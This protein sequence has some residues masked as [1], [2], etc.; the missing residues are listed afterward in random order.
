[1]T[2]GA[3]TAPERTSS[4]IASPAR[5]LSPY[6]S[7][8]IRAGSPWN[9]TRPGASSSQRWSSVSSGKERPERGVY[10]LDVGR[11]SG[12][13]RPPER[14]DATTEERSDVRRD[15]ARI[16][17]GVR[18]AGVTGLPAQV[19]AVVED[20]AACTGEL[21]HRPDVRHDRLAREAEVRLR[22]ALAQ[23]GRLLEAAPR[24]ARTR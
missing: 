16:R 11:V 23:C 22:I 12:Q 4:L 7:Q 18:E 20:V 24:P 17:E 1:M 14:P 10:R 21:G 5:A 6:P 9:A 15:E 19:V 13:H 2:T 3:E 8:Q